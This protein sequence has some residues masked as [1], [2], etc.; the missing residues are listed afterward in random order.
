MTIVPRVY[1]NTDHAY[2]YDPDT[3]EFTMEIFCDPHPTEEGKYLKPDYCTT[4]I[5]YE[6]SEYQTNVFNGMY[7]EMAPDYKGVTVYDKTTKESMVIT[8]IGIACPLTHTPIEPFSYASYVIWKDT[9]WIEDVT[10]KLNYNKQL[11][12]DFIKESFLLQFDL[13]FTSPTLN[14]K[15][16]CRRNLDSNDLQNYQ[17]LY[18]H[19]VANSIPS[20]NIRLFDNTM[21][22]ALT[23]AQIHTLI[24]ELIGY[25]LYLYN[26]KWQLENAID[27]CTTQAQLDALEW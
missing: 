23:Q 13:G 21:S 1:W 26:K 17:A 2:C 7:W 16:D 14:I 22:D 15:V 12:K 19:M 27:A 4:E 11:K 3:K 20:I 8:E 5:P 18:E 10:L 6:I 24:F 9:E 25:G